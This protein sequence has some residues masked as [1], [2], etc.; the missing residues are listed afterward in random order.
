MPKAGPAPFRVGDTVLLNKGC[1]VSAST[2]PKKN[3]GDTVKRATRVVIRQVLI[4]YTDIP[5]HEDRPTEVVW[6]SDGYWV[7]SSDFA[8]MT[9]WSPDQTQLGINKVQAPR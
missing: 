5:G 6:T 4:G 3:A 8:N 9:K 2:H 7:H 1:V